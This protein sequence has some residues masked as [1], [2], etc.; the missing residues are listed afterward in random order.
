MTYYKK[1]P[2]QI[3]EIKKHR[4]ELCDYCFYGGP[5]KEKLRADA[6]ALLNK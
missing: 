3:A 6:Q 2:F 5:D 1:F 4:S